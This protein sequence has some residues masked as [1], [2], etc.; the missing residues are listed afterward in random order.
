MKLRRPE[1]RRSGAAAVEAA[2]IVPVALVILLGLITGAIMVFTVDEVFN[3]AREGAR[4]GSVRGTEYARA[5]NKPAATSDEIAAYVK[6]QGV[7]LDP[8]RMTVTTTW[9]KTN[10][11]GQYITV[12]VT[13][14]WPGIWSFGAQTFVSSSTQLISY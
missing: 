7:L 4:Y 1:S 3:V 5:T 10:R 12:Q 6:Q 9:D 11:P 2:I 13:Y 8:S 14:D